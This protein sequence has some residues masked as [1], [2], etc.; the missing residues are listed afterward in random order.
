[1]SLFVLFCLKVGLC[2]FGLVCFMLLIMGRGCVGG[3]FVWCQCLDMGLV[4]G[5]G[6]LVGCF[7]LDVVF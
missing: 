4:A 6:G 7:W 2:R 5:V 1:M 3:V